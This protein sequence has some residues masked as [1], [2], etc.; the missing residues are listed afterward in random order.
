MHTVDRI[1]VTRVPPGQVLDRLAGYGELWVWQENRAIPREVLLREIA[2]ADGLYCMLTDSIDATLLAAAPRLRVVS[3]MAVGVDNIDLAACTA[4]GIPVG[5]TPDVLTET[6]ADTAFALLLAAARR[7]VEGVDHVRAGRWG[8]WDPALFLGADVHGA[9]LGIVG[10]GRIGKAVARRARGFGMK[11]LYHGRTRNVSAE[12]DLGVSFAF[13][14]D[15]L[16]EADHVVL[17]VPL[18]PETHHLIN[19]AALALMKPTATLVN[20]ARGGLIDPAALF[21]ALRD[22]GIAAAGLDVTEPEP[23]LPDDPLLGLPNCVILPHLGSASRRTRVA[24]AELAAANLSAGL[25]GEVL[26]AVANP[27]V[28]DSP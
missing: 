24:M 20:A 23:I 16:A 8:P 6:T 1:V 26:P 11:I 4:R 18:T 2:A 17:Q 28:Y 19:A 3:T 10:L 25:R 21:A 12:R 22:G 14:P 7:V 13:L 15:L 27:E 5:H 9:T